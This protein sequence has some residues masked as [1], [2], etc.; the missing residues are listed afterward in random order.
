MSTLRFLIEE[1]FSPQHLDCAWVLYDA[2]GERLAEGHGPPRQWPGSQTQVGIIAASRARVI[3]VELPD[4]APEKFA[5][6]M[7]Y[8]VETR[9]AGDPQAQRLVAGPREPD[10]KRQVVIVESAWLSAIRAALT[11]AGLQ[12]PRLVAQAQLPDRAPDAWWWHRAAQGGFLLLG[13]DLLP[14]DEASLDLD[15]PA[16]LLLALERSAP[17]RPVRLLISGVEPS[18][19]QQ[20][21]WARHLGLAIEYRASS[22]WKT[23]PPARLAAA[24][25]LQPQDDADSPVE[26]RLANAKHWRRAAQLI[27][28]AAGLHLLAT[29]A[30]FARMRWRETQLQSEARSLLKQHFPA[31]ANAPDA[32]TAFRLQH[33]AA[34]HVAGQT[35]A[36]DAWPLLARFAPALALL[37]EDALRLAHYGGGRWTLDLPVLSVA[38]R[39]AFTTAL[40]H[41]G[42]VGL[43]AEQSGGLRVLIEERKP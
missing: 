25:D 39:E 34:R 8:V 6:A 14:L 32:I 35:A 10:G 17:E 13:E 1:N 31:A 9:I 15:P 3:R 30:D 40:Q 28:V 7:A 29:A 21:A 33:A 26:G 24:A 43:Y 4:L 20:L 41:A 37:G 22:D 5:A 12:D 36:S 38:Q 16:T 11:E 2:H 18:A 19:E 23:L 27:F 42:L